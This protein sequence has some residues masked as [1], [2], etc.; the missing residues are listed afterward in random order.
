MDVVKKFSIWK[1]DIAELK[2][3][4]DDKI[5]Q[6][7]EWC[8]ENSDEIKSMFPTKGKVY[9][10]DINRA[11]SIDLSFVG[12][13]PDIKYYFRPTDV[14]FR[15]SSQFSGFTRYLPS[16]EGDLLCE[17][18]NVIKTKERV[19]FNSLKGIVK[20]TNVIGKDGSV[21]Y[22][23][24][25]I[26]KNTGYYKIGKSKNP[27]VREKTLQSEKPTIELLFKY[28]AEFYDEKH[29]H[30]V[31]RHKRIRGEWFDL[32]GSDLKIIDEYFNKN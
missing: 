10:I 13:D 17:F 30:Y 7:I 22:V 12:L 8:R 6:R 31:F 24:I 20:K 14:S 25:M 29:L 16:I 5:Q 26:D 18:H 27:S 23:Y 21:R 9:D 32:S 28:P 15:P 1:D 4:L 11:Y 19:N 3:R 2:Q